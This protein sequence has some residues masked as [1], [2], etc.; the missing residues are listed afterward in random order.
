MNEFY[1]KKKATSDYLSKAEG[2]F[3]WYKTTKEE[4]DGMLHC[5]ATND[6]AKQSHGG[7]TYQLTQNTTVGI[8]GAGATTQARMNGDFKQKTVR[9]EKSMDGQF[10]RLSDQMKESLL[11]MALKQSEKCKK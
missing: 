7:M 3:S 10:H 4:Q 11:A 6:I 9:D 1:D 2:K 8:Y 5:F